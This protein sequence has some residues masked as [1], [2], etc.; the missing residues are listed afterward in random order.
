MTDWLVR[1]QGQR[2]DLAEASA[3]FCTAELE[4]RDEE[5]I[6]YLAASE[7]SS[8]TD[9]SEVLKRAKELLKVMNGILKLGARNYHSVTAAGDVLRIGEDGKRHRYIYASGSL[10]G[11]KHDP[12]QA[13]SWFAKAAQDDKVGWALGLFAEPTL[14]KLYNILDIIRDDVGGEKALMD[15]GWAAER[16]IERFKRT[17]NAREAAGDDA[18]HGKNFKPPKR[19]MSRR[20]AEDLFR[21]ILNKWLHTKGE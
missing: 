3:C 21:P 18:R 13:R 6:Y 8:M 2:E 9:S 15:T 12:A 19:P 11:R 14:V 17:V 1:L 5:G 20:E 4:V 7:F 10:G 16:E